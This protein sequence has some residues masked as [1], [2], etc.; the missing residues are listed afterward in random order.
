MI[1]SV[2]R[3]LSD[4]SVCGFSLLVVNFTCTSA[5][6]LIFFLPKAKS[7]TATQS[8]KSSFL[9]SLNPKT[10]GRLG[11]QSNSNNIEPARTAG[12]SGLARAASKDTISNN[13]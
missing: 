5:F 1:Y 13:R 4:M 3:M 12:V 7:P 9:A 10:W 11:T 2:H 6:F 8:P